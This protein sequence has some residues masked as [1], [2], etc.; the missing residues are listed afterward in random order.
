MTCRWRNID[1]AYWQNMYE[2]YGYFFYKYETSC[3]EI[4]IID[5]ELKNSAYNFCPNCS[6]KIEGRIEVKY[7]ALVNLKIVKLGGKSNER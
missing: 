2:N 3:G 6:K 1:E 5:D 4:F 7:K